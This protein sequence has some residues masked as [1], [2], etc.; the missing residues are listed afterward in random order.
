MAELSTFITEWDF[1]T[2]AL[3]GVDM[4]G[5]K[6]GVAKGVGCSWGVWCC[7]KECV[8]MIEFVFVL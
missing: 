8:G 3:N 5:G 1:R 2:G 6:G 4:I 7:C